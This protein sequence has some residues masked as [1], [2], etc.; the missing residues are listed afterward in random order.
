MQTTFEA[1]FEY[2]PGIKW[3]NVFK[4]YWPAYKKWYVKGGLENRP[5][6]STCR[7]QLKNYMPEIIP[8]YERLCEL[9]G[10]D[11]LSA[12]FLSLYNPP[13]YISGCSQIIW[14]SD[15]PVLIRNYDYHPRL[16]DGT[17]LNSQWLDTK[18][19]AFSDCLI[20]ALDGI[21]EHGLALSLTFGGSREVGNGFGMPLIL[22]YILETCST[23]RQAEMVLRRVP[24]HMAYNVSVVDE[25]SNFVTAYLSPKHEPVFK[26]SVRI[27]TNHQ[28]FDHDWDDY[29]T[30]TATKEREIILNKQLETPQAPVYKINQAFHSPPLYNTQYS[31]GF[32]TLY[33]A[34]Y[35]PVEKLLEM[36][37]PDGNWFLNFSNFREG[38]RTIQYDKTGATTSITS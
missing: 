37:W 35:Y 19:I 14:P 18:V 11:D 29:A 10:G 23:T 6:Y 1:I 3:Q 16:I 21:N 5:T 30:A 25:N 28:P 8:V 34:L 22:R 9:S 24:S 17:I 27:A 13:A 20:G 4:R 32:G 26:R 38:R 12:R 36:S 15:N 33:T 2:K 7:R 31:K